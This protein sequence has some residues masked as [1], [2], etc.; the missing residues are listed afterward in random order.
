M[1]KV[2]D[3]LIRIKNGYLASKKEIAVVNSKLNVAILNLL[4]KEGFVESFEVGERLIAVSLR[5][6]SDG[7]GRRSPALTDVKRVSKPGRRIY[8]GNKYLPRV[9]NGLGVAIV[10][11]PRG[12]MTD[13]QARKEGVGGEVMAYVW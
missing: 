5:Y 6:E 9:L 11:T 1:D 13:K 2:G 10:S 7:S 8:K 4:K 3:L 12:I